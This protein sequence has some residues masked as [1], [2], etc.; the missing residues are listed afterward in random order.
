MAALLDHVLKAQDD[1]LTVMFAKPC[2]GLHAKFLIYL[3]YF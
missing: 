2:G 3:I 1:V